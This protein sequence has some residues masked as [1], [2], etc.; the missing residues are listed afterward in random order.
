MN[1]AL[2]P[3]L[4]MDIP[5]RIQSNV[6]ENSQCLMECCVHGQWVVSNQQ[7]LL[8]NKLRRRQMLLEEKILTPMM[9][10]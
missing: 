7:Q 1:P 9:N 10:E 4:P 2:I 3:I 8:H 6:S 5:F